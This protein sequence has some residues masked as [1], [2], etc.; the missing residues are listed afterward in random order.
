MI[1]ITGVDNTGKSTLANHLSETFGIPIATRYPVLPPEDGDHWYNWMKSQIE[2]KGE[3]IHDR[4]FMDELVYGPV[5]RNGYIT[6]IENMAQLSGMILIKQPLL[7]EARL[8]AW[9]ILESFNE[10]AQYPRENQIQQLLN[11]F[12]EISHLW[13]IQNLKHRTIFN[14][15]IDSE[16][17]DVD[18]IVQQY[19]RR[20]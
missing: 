15:L 17:N 2:N 7:I 3:S 8:P 9:K 14:Y 1:I 20:I 6:S 12:D 18:F 13:P 19:L 4:F 16:F 5:M 10:R 11:R